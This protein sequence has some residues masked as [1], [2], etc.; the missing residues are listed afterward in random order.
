VAQEQGRNAYRRELV[1]EFDKRFPPS[2][3]RK[4]TRHGNQD[5]TPRMVVWVSVIMF[6]VSGK[7]LGEQFSAARRIVKFLRPQWNVPVS[8]SAR[9]GLRTCRGSSALVAVG[10][11]V[12]DLEVAA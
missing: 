10:G 2:L 7:T 12:A 9:F 3:F 8:D 1:A 6:W 11:T 5:W 4:R